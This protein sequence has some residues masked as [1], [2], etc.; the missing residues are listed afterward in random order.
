MFCFLED[1]YQQ[2]LKKMPGLTRCAFFESLGIDRTDY[3]RIYMGTCGTTYPSFL[4]IAKAMKFSLTPCQLL[5]HYTNHRARMEIFLKNR[6]L[7][8]V[9][10]NRHSFIFTDWVLNNV[11]YDK[12]KEWCDIPFET[13]VPKAKI[14]VVQ[15]HYTIKH[16][17]KKRF[18]HAWDIPKILVQGEYLFFDELYNVKIFES[19]F[20]DLLCNYQQNLDF[21]GHTFQIPSLDDA[22]SFD[23]LREP[24]RV[25]FHEA[26]LSDAENET[27]ESFGLK[28]SSHFE[29]LLK[30]E[31]ESDSRNLEAFSKKNWRS[32][33]TNAM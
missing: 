26:Y 33:I 15:R 32:I 17:T 18:F 5:Y 6:N 13:E 27:K 19:A 29:D 11:P 9:K 23:M 22:R 14:K 8:G 1:H 30:R 31:N 3:T 12:L 10:L 20:I 21:G 16:K 7:S 28:N 2:L 24:S 4:A 25:E